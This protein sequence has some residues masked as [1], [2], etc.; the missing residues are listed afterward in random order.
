MLP[1]GK[2]KNESIQEIY[3]KDKEYLKW[4]NKQSWFRNK[5][6]T[7]HQQT[8]K[9]LSE[10]EKPI[11][12]DSDTIVVYTD[13]GCPGNGSQKAKAG[14][15]VYFDTENKIQ[16]ENI[17][18]ERSRLEPLVVDYVS[19]KSLEKEWKDAK[20]LLKDVENLIW[21]IFV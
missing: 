2:Y 19:L 1:F 20:Q 3:Q 8:S 5:F 13:G 10:V 16:M 12:V 18:R 7:L 17:S 4:L 21:Y 15:G 6:K 14:I 11:E 9:Q